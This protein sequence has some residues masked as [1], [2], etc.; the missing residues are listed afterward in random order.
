MALIMFLACFQC[1]GE[2]QLGHFFYHYQYS[3][4]MQ[5][6]EIAM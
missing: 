2:V 6:E 1:F 5:N 3:L 4:V